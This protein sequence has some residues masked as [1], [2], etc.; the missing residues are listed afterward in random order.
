MLAHKPAQLASV[1]VEIAPA[2]K[3]VLSVLGGVD[4]AALQEAYPGTPVVRLMP[5]TP[6]EV[7]RGVVCYTPGDTVDGALEAEVVGLLERL[8]T[9]VRLARSG[10][11]PRRP[12]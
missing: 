7:R 11:W 12:P 4:L 9:V 2:A 10:T 1:A 8:G 6:V 3:V 5:N